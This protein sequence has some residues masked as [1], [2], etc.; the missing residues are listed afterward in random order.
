MEKIRQLFEQQVPMSD[1]DWEIFASKLQK[2][3]FSSKSI[4]LSVG[5]VENHLS[6]IESG[7]VRYYVPKLEQEL[8]FGFSFAGEFMS[9][10]DS[11]LSRSP[12]RCIIQT[13][14]PTVLWRISHDDLQEVYQNSTVGN[15]VGRYAAEGLFL[16]KAKRELALLEESAEERYLKL[17]EE[18]PEL[19]REIP[20][21]YIAS[22]IG[23][24]PQALSRI[25]KRIS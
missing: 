21:K 10:Y 19:I 23:I 4:V 17:F 13:L 3:S 1:K 15:T 16:K 9:A 12:S 24:T 7:A 2:Q 8:T 18:R 20:L 6:Y 5:K 22:Y 25:R 14:M 11:F